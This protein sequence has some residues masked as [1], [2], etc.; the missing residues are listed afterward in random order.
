MVS[1]LHMLRKREK[2]SI[3]TPL[4]SRNKLLI[5]LWSTF[6]R[7]KLFCS[8][9]ALVAENNSSLLQYSYG[10][11]HEQWT[12]PY[13]A[14]CVIDST[15]CQALEDKTVNWTI[16]WYAGRFYMPS[17]LVG[18]K[19]FGRRNAKNRKIIKTL[20]CRGS[21]SRH[22]FTQSC[23]PLP[24]LNYIVYIQGFCVHLPSHKLH[25]LA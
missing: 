19:I 7:E 14:L 12:K 15:R 18:I 22:S 25:C 16:Q 4:V 8:V 3:K 17:I 9:R 2:V 20:V 11:W 5:E 21:N 6:E 13:K 23:T 24:G 10:L 1:S